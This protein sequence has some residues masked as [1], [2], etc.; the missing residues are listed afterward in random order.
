MKPALRVHLSP[1][2]FEPDVL[3]GGI[4][5]VIDLLRAST[6]IAVA[7]ANGASAVISCAEVDEA[8]RVAAGLPGG[9]RLLGGERGG[10]RID[11]FDLGNSPSEYTP[12]VVRGKTIVFTTTNGTRALR[13]AEHADRVLVGALVNLDAVV[14]EVAA[15]GRPVHL[16]CAGVE[17]EVCLEDTLCAG[18]YAAEIGR[19]LGTNPEDDPAII[20]AVTWA[21]YRQ[22]AEAFRNAMRAS[23]GGRNVA[24][25]GL[26]EDV[27]FA[28]RVSVVDVVPELDRATG[29][30]LPA[31][32]TPKVV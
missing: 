18:A 22:S 9:T 30:L 17:E 24:A 1:R 28:S 5:V 13:R 19:A 26:L 3:R 6:T 8:R 32:R 20:A 4:A 21:M 27:E 10:V 14:R 23:H 2:L 11:G 29:R 16:V 15:D 12:G 25:L 7:L 31:R